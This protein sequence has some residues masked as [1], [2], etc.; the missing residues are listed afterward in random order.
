M[1]NVSQV[2]CYAQRHITAFSNE[3]MVAVEVISLEGSNAIA[4][5]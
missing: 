2:P 3:L 4:I 1:G 5:I